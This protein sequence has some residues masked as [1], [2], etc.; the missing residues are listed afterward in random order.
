M[1]KDGSL[2]PDRESLGLANAEYLDR[3]YPQRLEEV[4]DT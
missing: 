4:I 3:M 1:A 2:H